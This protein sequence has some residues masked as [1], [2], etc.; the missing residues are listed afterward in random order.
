LPFQAHERIPAEP[1]EGEEREGDVA[2][3]G[4]PREQRDD[5]VGTADPEMGTAAARHAGDVSVEERDGAPVGRK[6]ARDQVEE[7][8]LPGAVGA[9][10]QSALAGLDG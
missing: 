7:R 1:R 5:L 4:V 9:D 10:D 8:R 2:Q 6:L 3:Q